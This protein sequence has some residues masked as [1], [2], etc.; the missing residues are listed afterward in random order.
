MI[1]RHVKW[2]QLFVYLVKEEV[3]EVASV[4]L[5]TLRVELQQEWLEY[6]LR[7]DDSFRELAVG[8]ELAGIVEVFCHS[9]KS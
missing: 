3:K 1:L 9:N 8:V 6:E 7:V 2:L 5:L 4:L